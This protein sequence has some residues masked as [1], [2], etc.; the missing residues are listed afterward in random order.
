MITGKLGNCVLDFEIDSGSQVSTIKKSD[1]I[2][3]NCEL[4]K[5]SHRL[6]G[7]GG[8]PINVLGESEIEFFFNEKKCKHKFIIV[9]SKNVNLV[10]RDLCKKLGINFAVESES[11]INNLKSDLLHEFHDFLNDEYVSNVK[12]EMKL[13]LKNA[14]PVFCKARSVPVKLKNAVKQELERLVNE[15]IL[16]KVFFF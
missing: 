15:G 1:F 10:G 5:T 8:E 3:L 7:Y 2:K 13:D 9:K 4:V 12:E 6:F 16:T 14:E 11:K